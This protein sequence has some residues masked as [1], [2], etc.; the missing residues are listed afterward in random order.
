[1]TGR[2][3][4]NLDYSLPDPTDEDFDPDASQ[5]TRRLKHLNGVLTHFW[6]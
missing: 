1:M 2:L 4:D 5:L 3:P 6:N